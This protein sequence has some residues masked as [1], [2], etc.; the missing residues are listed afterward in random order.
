MATDSRRTGE[1]DVVERKLGKLRCNLSIP[2]HDSH[3]RRIEEF[4]DHLIDQLG[5]SLRVEA[6]SEFAMSIDLV[7]PGSEEADE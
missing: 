2:Q 7:W 4:A 3:F 6:Q 5:G 1:H